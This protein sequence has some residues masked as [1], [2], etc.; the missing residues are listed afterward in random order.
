MFHPPYPDVAAYA[1]HDVAT[2]AFAYTLAICE[3]RHLSADAPDP[4][5]F[6]EQWAQPSACSV[7]YFLY[8]G[9]RLSNKF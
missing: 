5:G 2:R 6:W 7:P 9:S 3:G 8:V 4:V 1:T